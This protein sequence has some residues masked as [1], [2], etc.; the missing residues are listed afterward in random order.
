MHPCFSFRSTQIT[1]TVTFGD[2]GYLYTSKMLIQTALTLL[3]ERQA[4]VETVGAA[5]G[6]FTV[7]ALF[8]NSSLIDRLDNAGVRFVVNKSF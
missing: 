7:G 3:E 2:P 5:G 4:L 6:V 8:R 1:A